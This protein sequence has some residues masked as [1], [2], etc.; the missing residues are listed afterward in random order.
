MT[1]SY[2]FQIFLRVAV[3]N[4][5]RIAQWVIVDKVVQ[6]RLLRHGHIQCILNPG[7]VNGNFSPIPEQQFHAS[8]AHVEFAGSFIDFIF[9]SF[10]PY[11]TLTVVCRAFL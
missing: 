5:I 8:G 10:L 7:T 6:F 2:I 9:V 3:Q 11:G 1:S 4:Q